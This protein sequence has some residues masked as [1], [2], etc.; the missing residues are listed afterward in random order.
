MRVELRHAPSLT[1]NRTRQTH[2][3]PQARA[4][5]SPARRGPPNNKRTPPLNKRIWSWQPIA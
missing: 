5:S 2:A 1:Q 4:T 3:Y